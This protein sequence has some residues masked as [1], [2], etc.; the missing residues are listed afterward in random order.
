MQMV[1]LVLS[2]LLM[3]SGAEAACSGSGTSWSCTAGSTAADV[4]AAHNSATSGYTIT[5]AVGSYPWG[6]GTVTLTKAGTLTG[7]GPDADLVTQTNTT[8]N[9][10]TQTCI[11]GSGVAIIS[12][13]PASDL[14]IRV[15]KLHITRNSGVPLNASACDGAA[16]EVDNGSA[17]FPLTL[18]RIDHNTT[19]GGGVALCADGWIEGV[20]D[21]NRLEDCYA[22]LYVRESIAPDGLGTNSWTRMY[23]TFGSGGIALAG[24]RHAVF[25]EDNTFVHTQGAGGPGG[26]LEAEPY[27]DRGGVPVVRYNTWYATGYGFFVPLGPHGDNGSTRGVPIDEQYNNVF[28]LNASCG[29]YM[30]QRGGSVLSHDNQLLGASCGTAAFDIIND[31][32]GSGDTPMNTFVWNNSINGVAQT[33][34]FVTNSY[35]S[36][37][38]LNQNYYLHAPQASGGKCSY[39]GAPGPQANL[40]CTGS[41][42]NAYFGYTPYTY[43]HPLQSSQGS[44]DLTPPAAP[45]GLIVR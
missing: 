1:W 40:T 31:G 26:P 42:A 36:P 41:G 39:T 38:V 32:G 8:C 15:T 30:S 22:C 24:S 21:H 45:T 35:G 13:A 29:G 3:A 25:F 43:P 14:S 12:V 2:V 19:D 34:G 5:L 37:V 16:F 6:T 20:F 23:T 9:P 11:T 7:T 44:T 18:T 4:R 27:T 10:G 28:H 33:S 17:A